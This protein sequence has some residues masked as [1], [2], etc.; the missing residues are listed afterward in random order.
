MPG[1]VQLNEFKNP[2]FNRGASVFKQAVWYVFNA[3]LLNGFIPGS[4]W[5]RGLLKLFGAKIGKGV[6]IKPYVNIKFPW[7]LIIGDN[8]WIGERVWLDNLD[9]LTIGTNC[10]IS[11][12][13]M[14]ICGNHDFT[15]TT[16]DL[17]TKPIVLEDGVWIGAGCKVTPGTTFGSHSLLTMGSVAV[18]NTEPYGIYSGNPAVKVKEREIR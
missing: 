9:Q 1:T 18:G 8:S 3:C 10:C 5:R 17:F 4:G 2:E 7:K 12:G 6:I 15:K 16:F 13:A 11:Q 14:L